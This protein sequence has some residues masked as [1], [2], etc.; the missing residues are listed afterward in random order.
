MAKYGEAD[1]HWSMSHTEEHR[2]S[3][4]SQYTGYRPCI[5]YTPQD[6]LKTIQII[7][8]SGSWYITH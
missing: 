1:N 5:I 7:A 8:I 4:N 6:V 2:D 3:I